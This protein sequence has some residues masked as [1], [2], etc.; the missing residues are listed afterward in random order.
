MTYI[1]KEID[2]TQATFNG[3]DYKPE[4][5]DIRLQGQAKSIFDLMK[6]AK[7][8]TLGEIE[9]ILNH[10]Q[11]SISAQLRHLR[12]VRFGSNS[13]NKRRR[14]D[15]ANGLFEYQLV[16]NPD[17]VNNINKGMTP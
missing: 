5:D 2:F 8:R 7:W 15:R 1:Q 3:S 12:K 14:G 6:D 9:D 17:A 11:A 16:V 4:V 10:P 13:I